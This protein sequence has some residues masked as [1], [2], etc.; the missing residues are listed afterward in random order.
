MTYYST[1]FNIFF[2]ITLFALLYSFFEFLKYCVSCV[3]NTSYKY[4]NDYEYTDYLYDND[5]CEKIPEALGDRMKYYER[6]SQNVYVV[7]PDM[8]FII[9]IDGRAF[10]KF[11]KKFKTYAFDAYGLPYSVELKRIMLLVANDLLHEFRPSTVYTH[12][13]EITLIFNAQDISQNGNYNEHIFGG[14]TDKLLSLI[15]SFASVC[16]SH[17]LAELGPVFGPVIYDEMNSHHTCYVYKSLI[18]PSTCSQVQIF[19]ARLLVFPDDK[20]HEI[21]NHMMWRSKG[22]CTR[23]FISLYCEKYIGKKQIQYMQKD[24]RLNEL[25][26]LGFD[27]SG[28]G[29]YKV[30]FAMKHGVFMKLNN[31]DIIK[32]V[33]FVFKEYEYSDEMY[34]FLT[35]KYA[36][37]ITSCE[38]DDFFNDDVLVFDSLNYKELFSVN[39]TDEYTSVVFS[40]N[41][42]DEYSSLKMCVK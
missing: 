36:D 20:F 8:P 11:T 25:K 10:S 19:D 37:F 13:D 31:D 7:E 41:T 5:V 3:Y 38:T 40:V 32:T 22:D 14:R 39:T 24:Q 9:R 23:N 26:T 28:N 42:T 4:Y 12:S 33:F 2:A 16:F 6:L 21:V 1:E 17:H 34:Y 29:Q 27:L 15:P 35:E 18:K 30:D